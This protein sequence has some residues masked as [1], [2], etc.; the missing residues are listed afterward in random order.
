MPEL[1]LPQMP[2]SDQEFMKWIGQQT[3]AASAAGLPLDDY[4]E[5]IWRVDGLVILFRRDRLA[6]AHTQKLAKGKEAL[7]AYFQFPRVGDPKE[8]IR[9]WEGLKAQIGLDRAS[10]HSLGF[11]VDDEDDRISSLCEEITVP[12]RKKYRVIWSAYNG[13]FDSYRDMGESAK[14]LITVNPSPVP[15]QDETWFV[16]TRAYQGTPFRII[17]ETQIP[18][19]VLSDLMEFSV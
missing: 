11:K 18:E 5:R 15:D 16:H 3:V 12:L 8:Q 6:A 2:E 19:E 9:A 14:G 13:E 4:I 17:A 1:Q 10:R 7:A